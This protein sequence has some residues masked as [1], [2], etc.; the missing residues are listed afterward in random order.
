MLQGSSQFNWKLKLDL[1]QSIFRDICQVKPPRYIVSRKDQPHC[2]LRSVCI[3]SILFSMY[4]LWCWQGEF[5]YELSA[6]YVGNNLLYSC[7]LTIDSGDNIKS[8]G[9]G[10]RRKLLLL[11]VKGL[12][13]LIHDCHITDYPWSLTSWKFITWGKSLQDRQE[14]GKAK[15]VRS[16]AGLL[17]RNSW[18]SA[19]LQI[20]VLKTN[21]LNN[22]GQENSKLTPFEKRRNKK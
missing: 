4:F 16:N 18:V 8:G 11:W 17:N 3:F 2:T 13:G 20:A 14:K 10:I 15:F 22:P 7:A 21:I 9:G 1:D 5:L 19:R 6:S 12:T